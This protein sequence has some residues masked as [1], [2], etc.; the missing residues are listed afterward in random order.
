MEE[1]STILPPDPEGRWK[2]GSMVVYEEV[3]RLVFGNPGPIV[4][5][6]QSYGSPSM[7]AI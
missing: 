3:P 6:R 1:N 7:G 2:P 4:A 5:E